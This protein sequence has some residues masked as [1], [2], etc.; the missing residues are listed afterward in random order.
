MQPHAVKYICRI[1][2]SKPVGGHT[3][4]KFVLESIVERPKTGFYVIDP[5]T[6]FLKKSDLFPL[7]RNAHPFVGLEYEAMSKTV[8]N[9]HTGETLSFKILYC[10]LE[11]FHNGYLQKGHYVCIYGM[12]ERIGLYLTENL[13]QKKRYGNVIVNGRIP[14]KNFI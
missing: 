6:L 13:F 9:P 2:L 14:E 1:P 12:D 3:E 5:E 8:R 10:Y 4:F 11:I 7:D